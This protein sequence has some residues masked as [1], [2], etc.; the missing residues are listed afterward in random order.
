MTVVIH[1]KIK[2]LDI[3]TTTKVFYPA[4]G[5]DFVLLLIFDHFWSSKKIFS[6]SYVFFSTSIAMKTSTL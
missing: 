4:G 6:Y 5:A 3:E 2:V 1:Q